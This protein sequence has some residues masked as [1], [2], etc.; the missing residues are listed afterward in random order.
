M[1]EPDRYF[2]RP[3]LRLIECY[4]LQAVGQLDPAAADHLATISPQL[5]RLY[6]KAGAWHEIVAQ[7]MHFGDSMSVELRGMWLQTTENA[8]RAGVRADPQSWAEKVADGIV[9]PR[10]KS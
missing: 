4:V 1:T 5:T 7:Q 6:G 9:A 3:F 8:A 10:T 2:G